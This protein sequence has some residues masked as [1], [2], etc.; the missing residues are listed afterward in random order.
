MA[1][2]SILAIDIGSSALKAVQFAEDGTMLASSSAQI[3]TAVG[4]NGMRTQCPDDWWDAFCMAVA[5]LPERADAE[6]I[7]FAGSMQ[8]LIALADDA[9]PIAPAI[10][11][12]DRRLA[13]GELAELE[14]RLPNDY[15][16]RVGNRPDPA[17]TILKLMCLERFIHR[18]TPALRFAFGAKDAVTFRLTG[19][20]AVDPT[21][22][23]TTGLMD[24]TSRTWDPVLL[25]TAGIDETR[26]P[27]ILP[28]DA[29]LGHLPQGI[30]H[31]LGIRADIPVFNG[32]GDAAAATWGAAAHVP[33]CAYAY[34]GTTGWVAATLPMSDAAAPRSVYTLADPID[35]QRAIIVS[36]FL[37]A[38]SAMEWLAELTGSG[39]EELLAAASSL[40]DQKALP[41]FVPY[42][43]GE[44][45]PFEDQYVRAAFLGLDRAHAAGAMAQSVM[46]GIA[47]AIRH[48]MEAAGL[49]PA[50]LTV[51]GGGARSALQ[52]QILADILQSE[53]A[54]PDA[55]QETTALG[56]FRMIAPKLGLCGKS[57]PVNSIVRPR[58][59]RHAH[60]DR[61]FAT[62]LAAS[63][64][65]RDHARDL[66]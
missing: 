44:R 29:V 9:R 11:Y 32:A 27:E 13:D 30:A 50:P 45:G 48:N 62:Y 49:P 41:L 18:Q 61:R 35:S 66:V 33:G 3:S 22:A 59:S 38:G 14:D 57:T 40:G 7:A 24:L 58:P 15:A 47:C 10:L 52:R 20:S 37:T 54:F 1:S 60:S 16:S 42:L 4:E 53:I 6:A 5:R 51:I 17:H 28:A 43:C 21:V 2:R 34:V 65:A 64:F 23:S 63:Q 46:E 55:S 31:D 56:I 25:D 39:V 19:R 26:L 8:N 36:P 12:S